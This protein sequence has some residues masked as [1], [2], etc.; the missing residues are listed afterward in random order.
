MTQTGNPWSDEDKIFG[1]LNNVLHYDYGQKHFLSVSD[2]IFVS[3]LYNNRMVQ[4]QAQRYVD[5]FR[6]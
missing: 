6:N 4:S 2:I 1:S 3:V 5:E